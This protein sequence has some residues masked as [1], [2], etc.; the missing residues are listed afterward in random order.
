M[1]PELNG[2]WVVTPTGAIRTV[3]ELAEAR[4]GRKPPAGS[5]PDAGEVEQ[6]PTPT[7]LGKTVTVAK[8]IRLPPAGCPLLPITG[9]TA[10]TPHVFAVA[11]PDLLAISHDGT[12]VTSHPS[13]GTVTHAA[14]TPGGFV[15]AGPGVVAV[16]AAGRDPVWTFRVPD[17]GPLP[18]HPGKLPVRIGAGTGEDTLSAFVLAGSWLFARLGEHHLLALDLATQHVAWVLGSNGGPQY[19]PVVWPGRPRFEPRYGVVAGRLLV[20]LSDGRRWFIDAASGRVTGCDGEE[21][22]GPVPPGYGAPTAPTPWASAPT[23]IG[24][25]R[26]AVADGP[27]LV[28]LIDTESGEWSVGYAA[29]GPSSLTGASSQIGAFNGRALV[30]VYRSHGVELDR[31]ASAPWHDG[32]AYIDAAR[33][34]LAHAC[35]D[36]DRVYLPVGNRVCAVA[37]RDGH[38]AWDVELPSAPPGSSWAVHPG[39]GALIVHPCQPIPRITRQS[40]MQHTLHEFAMRPAG[41][42][43]PGLAAAAYD[44]WVDRTIPVLVLDPKTG[45]VLDRLD[46]PARGP[47]LVARF[48]GDAAVIACGDRVTW[49]K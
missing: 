19:E 17:P 18:D 25:H 20:Q 37:W 43:L 49:L 1:P 28:R 14:D 13:P 33:I 10:T 48:D 26:I 35:A 40:V 38:M 44:A 6:N 45:A 5:M 30:A 36:A 8:T 32:P 29:D 11:G 47:V 12:T 2:Q 41:G 34:D 27:G 22:E 39:R 15:V 4:S 3:G 42:R 46:L 31:L 24:R 7:V 16:Y 9:T 21:I 23:L